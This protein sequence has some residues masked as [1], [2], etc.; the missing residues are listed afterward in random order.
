MKKKLLKNLKR[1]GFILFFLTFVTTWSQ[2]Q[3]SGIYL[4]W[5]NLNACQIWDDRDRDGIYL[6]EFEDSP[7]L[8]ICQSSVS[9]F[10]LINVPAGTSVSWSISGG[11][12]LNQSN[13]QIQIMWDDSGYGNLQIQY[14]LNNTIF[15]KSLCFEKAIR[16][17]ANFIVNNDENLDLGSIYICL[18]Q[19]VHFTNTSNTNNGSDILNYFWDFGDGNFSYVE[20]P[21]HS[22]ETPGEYDVNLWITNACGCIS[23]ALAKVKVHEERSYEI[24][25]P[26]VICEG[27]AEIY[28]LSFDAMQNCNDFN[29]DVQGGSIIDQ[30]GG[31]V[32]VEWNNIDHTGYG[33]LTFNPIQCD[34]ECG[35]PTTVKIPVIQSN[36]TI[37]GNT[38]ICEG[39]QS[40]YTLPQWPS[41]DIQW[42][43]VNPNNIE[44]Q[45]IQTDQRNEVILWPTEG[46]GSITLRAV[47][48]NTLL[49]CGGI[50]EIVI[51][52]KPQLKI[53][54][55]Q[56]K[57]CEGDTITCTNTNNES[58]NWVVIKNNLTIYTQNSINLQYSFVE[59][60]YYN[61]KAFHQNYCDSNNIGISVQE[62]PITPDSILGDVLACPLMS[63]T[64]EIQSPNPDYFYEWSVT[65]GVILGNNLNSFV[66][67]EF[68]SF[69]A[70]ISVK[71]LNPITGCLSDE[72]SISVE[73]DVPH[74]EILGNSSSVCGSSITNFQAIIPGTSDLF[75][76][77][78]TYYWSISNHSLGSVSSGQGTNNAEITWNNV[79]ANT[80]AD[81][82]L[83]VTK[84]SLPPTQITFPVVIQSIPNIQFDP[85]LEVAFCSNDSISV[86][87]QPVDPAIN[88]ANHNVIVRWILNGEIVIGN[89]SR[90]F[91]LVNNSDEEVIRGLSAQIISFDGC[92]GL[93]NFINTAVSVA[94]SPPAIISYTGDI[95]FC[96]TSQIN[97]VLTAFTNLVQVT[98]QWGTVVG[99]DFFPIT[100]ETSNTFTPTSFDTYACL[101]TSFNGLSFGCQR[102]SNHIRI[103]QKSCNPGSQFPCTVPGLTAENNSYYSDCGTIILNGSSNMAETTE[104]IVVGPGGEI[105]D[106]ANNTVTGPPGIYTIIYIARAFCIQDGT[107]QF[108]I[109]DTVQI[110][111]PFEPAISYDYVCNG[112]ET[113]LYFILNNSIFYPLLQNPTEIVQYF[114]D[115]NWVTLQTS[116]DVS[117]SS[118][119]GSIIQ[120]R[121]IN[122]GSFEG[123]NYECIKD[124][125][126]PT[127]GVSDNEIQIF[128]DN[129]CH[130][131]PFTFGFQD[132]IDSSMFSF[133]WTFEPGIT[134]SLFNPTRVFNSSGTYDVSVKISNALGCNRTIPI[135]VVVPEPCFLGTL[136]TSPGSAHVCQG[137]SVTIS[138]VP[139]MQNCTPTY[140]WR[141]GNTLLTEFLNQSSIDVTE[142]GYYW[143]E[144]ISPQGCIYE[145]PGRIFP[146]FNTPP[147]L[148][149]FAEN[150]YCEGTNIVINALSSGTVEWFINGNTVHQ[151]L[152][153][154]PNLP[155]G[156]YT[157]TV[158][159]TDQLNCSTTEAFTLNIVPSPTNVYIT[160]EVMDCEPYSIKLSAYAD[161]P[162]EFLW[163]NGQTG[164]YIVVNHGGAYQVRAKS[165]DC[166]TT[167][168]M[169][170]PKHPEVYAWAYPQGCLNYCFDH[171]PYVLGPIADVEANIWMVSGVALDIANEPSPQFTL[172]MDGSYYGN[173][174]NGECSFETPP[175]HYHIDRCD[176]CKLTVKESRIQLNHTEFCSY[177][178]DFFIINGTTQIMEI[179]FINPE[180]YVTFVPSSF[181]LQ[182]GVNQIT[183]I[184]IPVNGFVG[185]GSF[186]ILINGTTYNKFL[187]PFP[188]E[189]RIREFLPACEIEPRWGSKATD[190]QLV[191]NGATIYLTPNPT[192]DEAVLAWGTNHPIDHWQ[193]FDLRGQLL[194]EQKTPVKNNQTTI[195][196]KQLPQGTY[197][198]TLWSNNNFIKYF[199]IIKK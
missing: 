151:G 23:K 147:V 140:L 168:T 186:N 121:V 79:S 17:Q 182:P 74:V 72:I 128:I 113:T 41:T 144:L 174:I 115:G 172:P 25:C 158:K 135:Q 192:V 141:R 70:T 63:L 166:I 171:N 24:S 175:L 160:A 139:S 62:T 100:G 36:G 75:T 53:E 149:V 27:A 176:E 119:L 148:R 96:E 184:L 92:T 91:H 150:Q 68:S 138:Y 137:E 56:D 52:I 118:N 187:N 31:N 156:N 77:A 196:L 127:Y 16:P 190:N 14:E 94:P 13:T 57:I 66:N 111:I 33:Y 11:S 102:R 125:D 34:I 173:I 76:G 30:A 97:T 20:N 122:T 101:I 54:S 35:E 5:D 114:L 64:Y 155:E 117:I 133:D 185:N 162:V 78:D 93:S 61:I 108:N 29:W 106:L 32:L 130:D 83:L 1:I 154:N 55:N 8:L 178:A 180:N 165:G 60:G 152:Q 104:W 161:Q 87:I 28:S 129:Y 65:N 194:S 189:Y 124:Y 42:S 71:S 80:S 84:C 4:N 58:V 6:E 49:N 199:K 123:Q 143:L 22:F 67:V 131:T 15:T 159:A 183:T 10:N 59:S 146:K 164:E 51:Q 2:N 197:M 40:K 81:V 167:A 44:L 107:T 153:W 90:E 103:V 179:Q 157:V 109:N 142:P 39:K 69:P 134:N 116:G 12:I 82:V 86:T 112:M 105:V 3:N 198:L 88:L 73:A 132:F 89:I 9:N 126:I 21:Q 191:A 169:L 195:S 18:N 50:A 188:C 136:Q 38:E 45:L 46:V 110:L 163:N 170:V 99:D 120:L 181:I 145:V 177:T 37:Q 95:I 48:N 7:C 26:T 43:I 19:I 47:Y 193:L 85:N 98:Y